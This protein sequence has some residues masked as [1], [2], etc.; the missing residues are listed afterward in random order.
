MPRSAELQLFRVR[1]GV[2]VWAQLSC[3]NMD[4]APS[5]AAAAE[6]HEPS[7]SAHAGRPLRKVEAGKSE[8]LVEVVQCLR[9]CW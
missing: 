8:A 3:H 2:R 1:V 6:Q 7:R 5:A 9:M 4:P